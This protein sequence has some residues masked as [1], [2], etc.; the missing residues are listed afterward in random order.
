MPDLFFVMPDLFFVR[1]DL[2]F[3]MPDPIEHLS[4]KNFVSL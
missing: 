2:F 4:S 3:I 1:P